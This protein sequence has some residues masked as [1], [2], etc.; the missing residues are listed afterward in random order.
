ML[1]AWHESLP[2]ASSLSAP[3]LGLHPGRQELRRGHQ[4]TDPHKAAGELRDAMLGRVTVRL[5]QRVQM[6]VC[7]SMRNPSGTT[8]ESSVTTRPY[9]APRPSTRGLVG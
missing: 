4:V 7:L 2:L 9:P 1:V 3:A 8:G 5:S 6:T